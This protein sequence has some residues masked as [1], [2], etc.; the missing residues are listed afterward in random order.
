MRL[1][2]STLG[3]RDTFPLSFGSVRMEKF[4]G[5]YYYDFINPDGE[6]A[7]SDG[8]SCNVV[9]IRADYVALMSEC[10]TIFKLS[11]EEYRKVAIY[12]NL[13]EFVVVCEDFSGKAVA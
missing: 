8:E 7:Y 11:F 2:L 5:K 12:D 10:G 1:D 4:D 6:E 9:D 13:D 3:A